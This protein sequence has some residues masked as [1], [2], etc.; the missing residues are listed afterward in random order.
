M[1]RS[2]AILGSLVLLLGLLAPTWAAAAAPRVT[3]SVDRDPVALDESFQ[4]TFRLHG[5]IDGQPD[6]SVLEEDFQVLGSSRSLRTTFVG[7]RMTREDEYLVTLLPKRTGRLVIPS[8]AFGKVKSPPVTVEVKAPVPDDGE[9]T[10]FMEVSVDTESPYVQQQVILSIR[11][12]R[13]IEWREGSLSEPSFR[14]GE[15]LVERLGEDR[16]FEETRD[17]RH[18]RVIERRY[19]LFPQQ[20]GI[21]E[22]EP[23]LLDL[24]VPEGGAQARRPSPFADPFFDDFF[25]SRRWT[26]KLVRGPR[27]RLRVRP[28]PDTFQGGHWLPARGLEL[29]ETW[30]ADT[31]RLEA[32]APVTR[33]LT[34]VADG[35]SK[36]QLPELTP[37][38]VPGLRIY[39][40]APRIRETLG[41]DGVR[42]LA[43]WK[44]ALVP[45]RAGRYRLPPVELAWWDVEK[46]RA[47]AARLPGRVL[48]VQGGK[49]AS[50]DIARPPAEQKAIA[51][52]EPPSPAEGNVPSSATD[53]GGAFG[54]G[55]GCHRGW[56]LATGVAVGLW[57]ITLATWW[58]SSR[59]KRRVST[60]SE[61]VETTVPAEKAAEIRRALNVAAGAGD[62]AR[63]R[64][65]LLAAARLRWPDSP[66]RS[67]EALADRLDAPQRETL[68]VLSRH[69]YGGGPG[70]WDAAALA[71]V[72]EGLLKSVEGP[73]TKPVSGLAPLYPE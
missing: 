44:F 30:S 32:G 39:A 71:R 46:D 45:E 14:G 3:V 40:D 21:L 10:V 29:E 34:L 13:R 67:L 48:R 64:D 9:R 27:L 50:T 65:A 38:E 2:R 36:G 11:I 66:P 31:D 55:E 41:P 56:Q 72:G 4:V 7:G 59:K 53:E 61:K 12:F 70:D 37:P 62:A 73:R 49:D 54:V 60:A 25:S 69:L 26:R 22:L 1:R 68:L 35:V 5:E 17:G 33:T 43:E 63:L 8:V 15:V 58:W 57:L 6:F 20:S 42:T 52:T 19:A 24:R 18:W 23:L 16:H 47:A 28:V 51:S